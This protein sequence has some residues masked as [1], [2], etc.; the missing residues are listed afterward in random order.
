VTPP[1]KSVSDQ[2]SS[3]STAVDARETAGVVVASSVLST[4]V[5]VPPHGSPDVAQPVI[6]WA[7][8][9]RYAA[10]VHDALTV[11]VSPPAI[12]FH[13]THCPWTS[14]VV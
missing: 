2:N 6:R 11:P 7:T 5:V 14:V 12:R 4:A 3:E 10:P 1:A 8:A 9:T 13:N